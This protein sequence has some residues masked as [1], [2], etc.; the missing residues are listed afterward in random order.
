MTLA[1]MRLVKILA[2]NGGNLSFAA[3]ELHIAQSALSRRL[4]QLEGELYQQLFHRNGKR[5]NGLTKFGEEILDQV[6]QML[7]CEKNINNLAADYKADDQG[8]LTLA[9]TH[10]Q[11]RYFLPT[12]IHNFRKKYPL[13]NLSFQ[14]GAPDGL[15]K[16]LF[17]GEVDF[18]ICT[19][20]LG[21]DIETKIEFL[22]QWNHLLAVPN[23]HPLNEGTINLNRLIKYPLLTYIEGITGR[24]RL[25]QSFAEAGL[26]LKPIFSASDSDVL[27][28]YI[29]AG[30][31]VGV[32]CGMARDE[33]NARGLNAISMSEHLPKFQTRTAWLK[34]RKLR[35][36]EKTFL[37]ELTGFAHQ[38]NWR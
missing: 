4:Q 35:K 17:R 20:N 14:Q 34:H 6:N 29:K 18:I 26:E 28:E 15:V 27:I 25:A 2:E 37:Q 8:T 19:E 31:G 24:M 16:L 3:K 30:L 21:E 13:V 5:L 23:D 7:I 36:F 33:I 9:T 1:Q 38:L 12:P 22:Y 32:L 10:A 11:A